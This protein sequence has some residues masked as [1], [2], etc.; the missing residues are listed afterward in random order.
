MSEH[1]RRGLL[2]SLAALSA[3]CLG[4]GGSTPTATP[5]SASPSRTDS[6]TD[7]PT[8]ASTTDHTQGPP[9]IDAVDGSWPQPAFDGGRTRYDPDGTVPASAPR[10]AWRADF[11]GTGGRVVVG[12]GRVVVVDGARLWAFD[13]ADGERLWD[14]GFEP[15][16]R[17]GGPALGDDLYVTVGDDLRILSPADGTVRHE[18]ALEGGPVTDLVLAA[19]RLYATTAGTDES[20]SA[21]VAVENGEHRWRTEIDPEAGRLRQVA[22]GPGGV[23]AVGNPGGSATDHYAFD[24]NGGRR[25]RTNGINHS[26]ALTVADG[27]LLSSGFYGGVQAQRVADGARDWRVNVGAVVDTI[28]TAPDAVYATGYGKDDDDLYALAA[29]DG[30]TRWSAGP[31][32]SILGAGDG[33]VVVGNEIRAVDRADGSLRWTVD[34]TDWEPTGAAL[35]DGILFVAGT[36]GYLRAMV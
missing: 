16:T 20:P 33:L 24:R 14:R 29:A 5:R 15:Q 6:P 12:D 32:G 25:W 26:N 35:A 2:A 10:V 11:A 17:V 19:E 22:A 34:P 3:G 1:T 7:P 23:Y 30:T 9:E 28:G 21:L 36:D 4:P 18:F 13:A 8:D 31:G 27:R